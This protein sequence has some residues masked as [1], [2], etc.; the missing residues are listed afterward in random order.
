MYVC[1]VLEGTVR[2]GEVWLSLHRSFV[3]FV[4]FGGFSSVSVVCEAK[5]AQ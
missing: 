3:F 5:H 2:G 1:V 4:P